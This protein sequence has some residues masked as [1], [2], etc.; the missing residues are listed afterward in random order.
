MGQVIELS[1]L[2]QNIAKK[3]HPT[4]FTL[5]QEEWNSRWL[6]KVADKVYDARKQKTVYPA[7]SNVLNAFTMPVDEVRCVII[8]QDPYPNE[9]ANGYA[10]SCEKKLSPSLKR[11]FQGLVAESGIPVDTLDYTLQHWIDQGVMLLNSVLTVEASKP[12]SHNTF[13]W[14]KLVHAT[15]AKLPEN[16]P[17]ILWGANAEGFEKSCVGPVIKAEHPVA[18]VYRGGEPWNHNDCFNK[19]NELIDEQIDW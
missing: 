12:A 18:G 1:P 3:V 9:N 17:V 16:V 15:L 7:S 2:A 5:L 4:W 6:Q 14:Q 8:G 13:G 19:V 11:I 10:F